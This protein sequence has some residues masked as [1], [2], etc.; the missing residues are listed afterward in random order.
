MKTLK[1]IIDDYTKDKA[2]SIKTVMLKEFSKG[3][4]YILTKYEN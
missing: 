2:T 1:K 3:L 4:E